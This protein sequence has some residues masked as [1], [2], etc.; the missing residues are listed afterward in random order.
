MGRSS[1]LSL[2]L[3]LVFPG[4]SDYRHQLSSRFD[5][6]KEQKVTATISRNRNYLAGKNHAKTERMMAA[7]NPVKSLHVL[8]YEK[9]DEY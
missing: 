5:N 6:I 2:T 3:Q 9:N 7:R 4:V 8:L 1:V